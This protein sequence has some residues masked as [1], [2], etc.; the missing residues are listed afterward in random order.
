MSF[1]SVERHSVLIIL[2]WSPFCLESDKHVVSYGCIN[3]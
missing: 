1:I 3:R 2:V